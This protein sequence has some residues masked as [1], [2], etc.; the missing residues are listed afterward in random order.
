[1]IGGWC[2]IIQTSD[3]LSAYPHVLRTLCLFLVD[4]IAAFLSVI[5]VAEATFKP[6]RIG[7]NINPEG[8]IHFVGWYCGGNYWN[9]QNLARLSGLMVEIKPG[10][11]CLFMDTH[12][13]RFKFEDIAVPSFNQLSASAIF[14]SRPV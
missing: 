9:A 14:G 7:H 8:T 4:F 11:F 1:M 3:G 12:Y 10:C 5:L 13:F 2:L 6:S